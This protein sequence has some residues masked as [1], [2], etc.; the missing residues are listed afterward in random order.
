M[1]NYGIGPNNTQSPYLPP[2]F[3]LDKDNDNWRELISLRERSTANIINIKENAQYEKR[4]LLTAQQWFTSNV[5]GAYK[6]NYVFRLTFDL[7][8]LNGG[9]IPVGTTT[10]T[11][12]PATQPSSINIPN[13]LVPVHGFGA[14][15]N[16]ANFYFINDPNLYIRTNVW[17]NA[18]QQIIITNNTGANLTSCVWV[19]EYQKF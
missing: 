9:P 18:S 15:N 8:A 13:N 11:L 19:F 3:D 7:V 17:S 6:S 1:A 14:A 16:G 10:L 2:E 5:M 12:T 4:E